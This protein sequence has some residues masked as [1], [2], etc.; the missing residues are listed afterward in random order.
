MHLRKRSIRWVTE[1]MYY[2]ITDDCYQTI[3][4]PAHVL[5]ATTAM[6]SFVASAF[7]NALRQ[8]IVL[9]LHLSARLILRPAAL[10]ATRTANVLADKSACKV[11]AQLALRLAA[12]LLKALSAPMVCLSSPLRACI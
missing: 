7:R 3:T 9:A 8:Q 6:L 5:P 1:L 10:H 2:R 12:V 4:A 11:P